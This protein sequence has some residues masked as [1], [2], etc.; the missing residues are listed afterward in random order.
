[1]KEPLASEIRGDVDQCGLGRCLATGSNE[2]LIDKG[3][4]Q[5]CPV[6][7][8]ALLLLESVQRTA[9]QVNIK[10]SQ[11]TVASARNPRVGHRGH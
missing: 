7:A 1:M 2:T 10:R 8:V 5:M 4:A 3:E 9:G 11:V 6:A